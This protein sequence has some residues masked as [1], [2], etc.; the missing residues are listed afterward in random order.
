MRS[1]FWLL[2]GVLALALVGA[3]W[4]WWPVDRQTGAPPPQA[5]VAAGGSATPAS[6]TLPAIS[7]PAAAPAAPAAPSAAPASST[8]TANPADA[9]L[10]AKPPAPPSFDIVKVDPAGNAVIAG[11]AGP[12]AEVSVLDNGKP[13]GAATAN[14]RGEWVVIPNRPL[15]SGDRQ[16]SLEAADAKGGTKATSSATVAVSVAPSGAAQSALAVLL[17]GDAN[18]PA[19]ALQVPGGPA[20]GQLSLDSAEF[21]RQ[22]RLVLSGHAAPGATLN[23]SAGG[24][25]LGVATA[26][27]RGHWTLAAPRPAAGSYELRADQLKPNGGI[28]TS[29]VRSMEPSPA[30]ALPAGRQ[31]VVKNGNSLWWIARRTYGEGIQYSVIFSANRGQIHDPNL[32]FPGQVFTL[33]KS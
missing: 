18:K 24:R 30:M 12:G 32:I 9:V 31:Y 27:D 2:S 19:Q 20:S 17:P 33:P 28:A 7:A 25:P 3:A 8:A 10:P 15:A 4:L 16:L 23:L 6:P 21:D 26:D 1:K 11:R 13:V 29:I 22:D 14:G 5:S